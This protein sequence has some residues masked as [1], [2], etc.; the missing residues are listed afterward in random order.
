MRRAAAILLLALAAGPQAGRAQAGSADPKSW[1]T[2]S[3]NDAGWRY[4]PL[5]QINKSNIRE[6]A[7]KWV[8][9]TG[10][11][12][13]FETTPL[14]ENGVM[15]GTAQ[16]GKAFALD[17]RTGKAIWRYNPSM[18]G[19]VRACCGNV[20][21]GFAIHGD[22]L[23]MATLDAHVIALDK[24]TG[25]VLW[26][27]TAVDYKLGYSFTMAPLVVKDKIIVGISGGEFPIRGF[28]DAYFMETGKRAWRFYTI[29]GREVL[30]T[31]HGR[32]IRGNTAAGRHGRREATI[33]S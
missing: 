9:Q 18:P 14:V 30:A 4:S 21:R 25:N 27:T 33:R 6:L 7:P 24:R 5:E 28:V 12:G 32:E 10:D 3:G 15:Y 22:R 1:L 29:P 20:N 23:F 16:N 26:D 11:L 2:Y 17:A 13:K 19:D 8:F 31:N